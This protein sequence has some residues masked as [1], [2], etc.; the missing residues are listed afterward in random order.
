MPPRPFSP[1][2][3][4]AACALG[5]IAGAL[6]GG[7][8][9]W[10]HYLCKPLATVLLLAMA[11]RAALPVSRR[12][13]VL[14]C[15][16]LLLSLAGDVFLML[17]VDLFV[18]GLVSFLLAHLCYIAAF[19]GGSSWPSR[20]LALLAYAAVAAVN[21]AALLPHVPDA[22]KPAVLAYVAVLVLMA[23]LAGARGWSL[24]GSTLAKPASI[25]AIGGAL[26]VLSD[27]LLA[28]DKFGGGI[29]KAALF[30]LASYYAA[31]WCIAHSVESEANVEVRRG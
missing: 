23:A 21:L 22:L 14:V 30:V 27:S 2:L 31:Q 19:A 17:P 1:T 16:G 7:P 11:A 26:F 9:I 12:Y 13:R 15:T 4:V 28:W 20:A 5:A 18:A 3:P 6:L 10:L 29:P 8:W 24:R 25:A